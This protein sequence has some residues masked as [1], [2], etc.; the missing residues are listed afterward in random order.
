MDVCCRRTNRP[1]IPVVLAVWQIS[2][3]RSPT[4]DSGGFLTVERVLPESTVDLNSL[5]MFCFL[6]ISRLGLWIFDLTTQELTQKGIPV[7]ERSAFA[8]TEMAFISL[9]ELA[10]WIAGAILSRPDQFQW[11]ASGSLAAVF[12][13]A[14]LYATWVRSQRGHLIHLEKLDCGCSKN[15]QLRH[16][17]PFESREGSL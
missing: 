12:G 15:L 16:S 9:F 4:P 11:L 3:S 7:E 6:S 10:Q 14:A 2:N 1:Q 13:S 17:W 8:G 5:A